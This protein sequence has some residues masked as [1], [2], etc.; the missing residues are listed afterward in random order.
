MKDSFEDIDSIIIEF[1]N[2]FIYLTI[3]SPEFVLL[4]FVGFYY[5]IIGLKIL[6]SKVKSNHDKN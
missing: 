6:L 2:W 3:F 4:F 5:L 1:K